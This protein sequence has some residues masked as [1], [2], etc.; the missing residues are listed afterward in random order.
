MSGDS[1]TA[2]ERERKSREERHGTVFEAGRDKQFV[3]STTNPLGTVHEREELPDGE[4]YSLN[5]KCGQ[6]LPDNSLWA[7]IDA[8]TPEEVAQKYGGTRFCSRCF[9]QSLRL[10]R[11]GREAHR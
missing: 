10:E 1:E 5:P 6:T 9:T 7:G 8:D 4:G 11:I 3:A 2:T